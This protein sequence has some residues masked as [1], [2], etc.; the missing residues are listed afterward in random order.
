MSIGSPSSAELLRL[1]RE[2]LAAFRQAKHQQHAHVETQDTPSNHTNGNGSSH[3]DGAYAA[4]HP[5]QA[6]LMHAYANGH[7]QQAAAYQQQAPVASA[8]P[9]HNAQQLAQLQSQYDAYMQAGYGSDPQYAGYFAQLQQQIATLQQQVAADAHAHTNGSHAQYAT[10]ATNGAEVQ[11]SHASPAAPDYSASPTLQ[12]YTPEQR[13][14]FLSFAQYYHEPTYAEYY[15]SMRA[16]PEYAPYFQIM[17]QVESELQSI[18]AQA[19]AGAAANG[20]HQTMEMQRQQE[21]QQQQQQQQWYEQQQQQLQQ[22]QQQQAEQEARLADHAR[23]QERLHLE[24]AQREQLQQ[25]QSQQPSPHHQHPSDPNHRGEYPPAAVIEESPDSSASHDH[26]TSQS[27]AAP[28]TDAS[29]SPSSSHP[30]TEATD[31]HDSVNDSASPHTSIAASTEEVESVLPAQPIEPLSVATESPLTPADPEEVSF[32]P[33]VPSRAS[34]SSAA[35]LP[36]TVSLDDQSND[37]REGQSARFV[38]STPSPASD[39][40][41]TTP[42]PAANGD[43]EAGATQEDDVPTLDANSTSAVLQVPSHVHANSSD[44]LASQYAVDTSAAADTN[45]DDAKPAATT[46]DSARASVIAELSELRAALQTKDAEIAQLSRSLPHSAL[47]QSSDADAALDSQRQLHALSTTVQSL[48]TEIDSLR[49]EKETTRAQQALLSE[50]MAEKN[51]RLEQV[52]QDNVALLIEMEQMEEEINKLQADAATNL[53]S[54][55]AS[56]AP[57]ACTHGATLHELNELHL[58]LTQAWRRNQQLTS[59]VDEVVDQLRALGEAVDVLH[60]TDSPQ[61]QLLLTDGESPAKSSRPAGVSSTPDVPSSST[62]HA[63][64]QRERA[65]SDPNITSIEATDDGPSVEELAPVT[66]PPHE[67][68]SASQLST[69]Q[70]RPTDPVGQQLMPM[71]PLVAVV[72]ATS[73]L[74]SLLQSKREVESHLHSLL[75]RAADLSDPTATLL[76]SG[77]AGVS[78]MLKAMQKKASEAAAAAKPGAVMS[79]R[80]DEATLA[81]MADLRTARDNLALQLQAQVERANTL[82]RDKILLAKR[83]EDGVEERDL[84]VQTLREQIDDMQRERAQV[85]RQVQEYSNKLAQ[86]NLERT[87]A[88]APTRTTLRHEDTISAGS[89]VSVVDPEGETPTEAA[90]DTANAHNADGTTASPV[91]ADHTHSNGIATPSP[92]VASSPSAPL[93]STPP[94]SRAAVKRARRARAAAAAAAAASSAPRRGIFSSLIS[95]FVT[96]FSQRGYEEAMR[97]LEEQRERQREQAMEEGT[98]AEAVLL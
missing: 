24:A 73:S 31:K 70:R 52:A 27:S 56:P 15:T 14:A 32:P 54:L 77:D 89:T 22:Q 8:D 35:E 47:M 10:A 6:S 11:P 58:Q 75:R 5:S 26:V 87:T 83:I 7:S 69:P 96:R 90:D 2:K 48:S 23:E 46:D 53:K 74:H 16:Q 62:N 36:S 81:A 97:R 71:S 13:N 92:V 34:S 30:S 28:T 93:S 60:E 79:P 40:V 9:S 50:Q 20:A 61:Q 94:S 4:Y 85:D 3:V 42:P 68:Y 80:V 51:A 19:A 17:S 25:S 49:H 12:S 59:E 39:S 76:G 88:N 84:V 67:D 63:H 38:D 95:F 86:L 66:P 72:A 64:P 18:A 55:P 41:E 91:E 78:K 21:A 65:N 43:S 45:S 57:A 98:E 82:V 1:G 44:W 37:D 33:E 29:S